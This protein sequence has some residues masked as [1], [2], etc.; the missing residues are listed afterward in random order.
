MF[1]VFMNKGIIS[2]F[3]DK[4]NDSDM[5]LIGMG[6]HF[7]KN[8]IPD[9]EEYKNVLSKLLE[10]LNGKNYFIVTTL[11]GDIFL[12]A[13]VNRK[14]LVRPLLAAENE[15]EGKMWDFY[16]KWLS[17]TL[18]KKLLI[19]ELG[20]DFNHPNIFR[21]PFEKVTFINQKAFMYRVHDVFYQ[22]PD[23]I[24]ERSQSVQCNGYDFIKEL[25][26]LLNEQ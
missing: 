16:N 12:E 9:Q 5:I 18:N 1:E 17:C 20:E 15:E 8:V 4:Y 25:S 21:W 24:R 11:K 22:L 19:L 26:V 2:E 14:R 7:N 13:G 6:S 10:H 23:N 3:V